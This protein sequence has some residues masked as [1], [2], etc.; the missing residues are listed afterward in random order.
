MLG[1][2]SLANHYRSNF[3]LMFDHNYSLQDLENMMPWER[4]IYIDMY[5]NR[6]KMIEDRRNNQA[7][8]ER[9]L[10]KWSRNSR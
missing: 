8:L 10:N 9:H 4:Q 2:D 5:N 3:T 1:Y 7:D 6:M